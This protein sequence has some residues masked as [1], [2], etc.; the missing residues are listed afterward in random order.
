MSNT[1]TQTPVGGVPDRAESTREVPV[2]APATDIFETG[3]KLFV[4]A[5]I[6]GADP[7]SVEVTVERNILRIAARSRMQPPTGY[8]LIHAEYRYGDYERSF[9]LGTEVDTGAIEATVKDGVLTLVLP[10]AKP[11]ARKISVKAG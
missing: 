3:D 2:F 6:P 1:V 7:D 4:E 5:E 11:E 8:S 10:K 9:S